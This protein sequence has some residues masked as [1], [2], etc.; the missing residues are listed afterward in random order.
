MFSS[1]IQGHG[2]GPN[3]CRA[4]LNV[5]GPPLLQMNK[6]KGIMPVWPSSVALDSNGYP[7]AAPPSTVQTNPG[8]FDSYAGDI[9]W[10]FSGQVAI[11]LNGPV[12]V[13]D[14]GVCVAGVTPA[15]TG[16]AFGGTGELTKF[17]NPNNVVNPRVRFRMGWNIQ[18]LTQS[19]TSN[20]AGGFLIRMGVKT[21]FGAAVGTGVKV[22]ISGQT[23]QAAATGT[24]TLT[25]IDNQTYDLQGTTWNAGDPYTGPSGLA[26]IVNDRLA[27]IWFL[28]AASGIYNGF[29]NWVI[30][31]VAQEADVDAG[32]LCDPDYVNQLIDLNSNGNPG[33]YSGILRF[34]D[35]TSSAT[36]SFEG[37]YSQ[38]R[39]VTDANWGQPPTGFNV[40]AIARAGGDVYTCSNP[41]T[42]PASGVP[43]DGEVIGGTVAATNTGIAPTLGITGRAGTTFPVCLGMVNYPHST[44]PQLLSVSG[45]AGSAGQTMTL[46][47]HASWLTGGSTYTFNYV[48]VSGDTSSAG[49][50]TSN[51]ITALQADATLSGALIVFGGTAVGTIV[52]I[53]P[54]TAL[55]GVLTVVYTA[56]PAVVSVGSLEASYLDA[57]QPVFFVFS[58]LLQTWM[59]IGP[60]YI[61]SIPLEVIAELCNRTKMHC[62]YNWPVITTSGFVSSVSAFFAQ[63]LSPG[64]RLMTETTNEVWNSAAGV[65]AVAIMLGNALGFKNNAPHLSLVG[66]RTAQYAS[67]GRTAWTSVGKASTDYVVVQQSQ[68]GQGVG[69]P[70][71]IESLK[72]TAL[73]TTNTYYGTYGGLNGTAEANRNTSGNRP[74]TI[75][76]AIGCAPY[77]N[78][79]WLG[80]GSFTNA[81]NVTGT[82]AQNA[83][84][85]QAA[86][87]YSNGLTTQA[88]TS[89]VNQATRVTDRTAYGGGSSGGSDFV[90][91]YGYFVTQETVAKQ[92]DA[93]RI[94][95]GLSPMIIIHYEGAFTIGCGHDGNNGVNSVNSLDISALATRIGTG[96]NDSGGANWT[97]LNWTV[98]S[99]THSGADDKTEMATM[100]ITMLQAWKNDL[101]IS[102]M[103]Q[104][105][106]Y[107]KL[108]QAHMGRE[109]HPAQYGYQAN[110]W[111][112]FPVS[113]FAGNAYKFYDAMKNYDSDAG[114]H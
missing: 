19:P 6:A 48:T 113:A 69:S 24:W 85:L 103:V 26:S 33:A 16:D 87:D 99:Y 45:P 86:L 27:N 92:F 94:A 81:G 95:A 61:R 29:T 59:Y 83:P 54:P 106:Y 3:T 105:Y 7:M 72:G 36:A 74:A 67:I 82:V 101:S 98:S 60:T 79:H 91:I 93:E 114:I 70:W 102:S 25:Q 84:L 66:L 22:I 39:L 10:K 38:R 47:F 75:T 57:T 56:G 88:F 43:S 18:S 80:S 110:N 58:K 37:N 76:D 14:G 68:L 11:G 73:V 46:T 1:G 104:N 107:L 49:T 52:T 12:V 90:D 89:L 62:Y 108:R 109:C 44:T 17:Y 65:S 100:I 9:I 5:Q 64:L 40:G 41:A 51:L 35:L 97:G 4:L 32:K 28:P 78:T 31:K 23:G 96:G 55:A 50:L 30:C 111:C 34:M 77:T 71:D 63:N 21:G 13:F 42:S 8:W 15:N 2:T 20:G 112:L 53:Q